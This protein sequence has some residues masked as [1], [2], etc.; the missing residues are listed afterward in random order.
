MA[1][2]LAPWSGKDEFQS[3]DD[4]H[5]W[6]PFYRI[7]YAI[8]CCIAIINFVLGYVRVSQGK[9]VFSISLTA[10]SFWL[11]IECGIR[12]IS[13]WTLGDRSIGLNL[14]SALTLLFF[15]CG[16]ALYILKYLNFLFQ[17]EKLRGSSPGIVSKA[18]KIL[19]VFIGAI[20]LVQIINL[21]VP[22][23]ANTN[24][25]P[26]LWIT[27]YFQTTVLS[28]LF[29]AYG[30]KARNCFAEIA[31]KCSGGELY[32]ILIKRLDFVMIPWLIG[33][34]TWT[35]LLALL[36]FSQYFSRN[37]YLLAP[38]IWL[39][40]ALI[41]SFILIATRT[42][43]DFSVH[44]LETS[45]K[46]VPGSPDHEISALSDS[47]SNITLSGDRSIPGTPILPPISS[48]QSH[49]PQKPRLYTSNTE[50]SLLTLNENS[51]MNK[52]VSSNLQ[53]HGFGLNRLEE[54]EWIS[55][56]EVILSLTIDTKDYNPKI[57]TFIETIE[58]EN[59]NKNY[60]VV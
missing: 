17:T 28:M 18:K 21:I 12:L 41:C 35:V 56:D 60:N 31:K 46:I 40:G 55:Q 39:I 33:Y 57:I 48:S 34:I 45:P 26:I 5:V 27:Y 1:N 49:T 16:L 23:I 32:L 54:G 10:Y 43:N 24:F 19:Y 50:M 44:D 9:G 6:L 7:V 42:A 20:F 37:Q 13:G 2:C 29:F 53:T 11:I 8:L 22:T 38:F 15:W 25:L 59:N 58:D 36:L 52:D 4:C 47:H 51:N 14:S 30:I 3:F